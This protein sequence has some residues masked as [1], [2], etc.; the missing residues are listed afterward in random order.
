MSIIVN[1]HYQSNGR[2]FDT[3][4]ASYAFAVVQ[5]ANC[6][7]SN[8]APSDTV[9]VG[10]CSETC[11]GYGF[12]QCGSLSEGLYGYVALN[13][14][15]SGTIG[16]STSSSSIPTSA[17]TPSSTPIPSSYQSVVSVQTVSSPS[18]TR[19]MT[20]LQQSLASILYFTSITDM[21]Q[22]PTSFV[23]SF[24]SS[25]TLTTTSMARFGSRFDSYLQTIP[26]TPE[27]VTVEQ[28][29]TAKPSVVISVVSIVRPSS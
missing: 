25:L 19:S 8:Y 14:R 9:D 3:C 12:E 2:C 15:P 1:D 5:D 21:V 6:W 26:S 29:V 20:D 7:C 24:F 22:P 27:P 10:S 28:T 23:G 17:S 11:P 18:P 13:N 4:K 16:P